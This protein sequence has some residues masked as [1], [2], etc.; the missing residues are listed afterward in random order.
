MQ[1][2][3]AFVLCVSLFLLHIEVAA[4]AAT[5]T[6]TQVI[7]IALTDR[8][9][10]EVG[11]A[12]YA[13]ISVGTPGQIQSALVDTGSSDTIFPDSTAIACR[14][15]SGCATT[16]VLEESPDYKVVTPGGLSVGYRDHSK[17]EGDYSVDRVQLGDISITNARIG[18]AKVVEDPTGIK[19]AILGLGYPSNEGQNTSPQPYCST[20]L[21]ALVESGE[22]ESRLYGVYL[23]QLDH[24][25]DGSITFGGIDTEKFK[26]PLTT[27]NCPR[28]NGITTKLNL[29][30]DN[31]KAY[32]QDGSSQELMRSASD[33]SGS[34]LVDTGASDWRA[35]EPVYRKILM[36]A[37]GNDQRPCKEVVRGATYF[38]LTFSGYGS[39]NTA[40]LNV[41]MADLFSPHAG[42]CQLAVTPV[43]SG[44]TLGV[45]DSVMRAGY[46]VFDLD[47][48]Q[49][50]VAQAN[51]EASSSNVV[52]VQKGAGGLSKAIGRKTEV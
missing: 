32:L 11:W 7:E 4:V 27:L 50:S 38:Q 24:V 30:L 26:G 48:G 41:D 34:V 33:E 13:N 21:Q 15:K 22:I 42:T 39:T 44:E 17:M 51:L 9:P 23:G 12:Y 36:L 29:K 47:N 43:S 40:T 5:A 31:V 1:F 10:G 52:K 20:L 6:G 2:F 45:G 18:V 28:D 16:F 8:L 3:K 19:T 35:S 49:I 25:Q 14:T 37:G 46:W